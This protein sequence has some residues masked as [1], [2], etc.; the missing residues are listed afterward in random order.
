MTVSA[1]DSRLGLGTAQVRAAPAKPEYVETS[2]YLAGYFA[3]RTVRVVLGRLGDVF[4]FSAPELDIV[5][6]AGAM[7]GA[8]EAFLDRVSVRQDAAW[9][10]FDVGPLR[11]AELLTALDAPEDEDW[12][13]PADRVGVDG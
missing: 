6:D 7:A 11:T 4:R 9:L 2:S 8:W 3:V 10:S 5:V 12:A 13:D 1:L